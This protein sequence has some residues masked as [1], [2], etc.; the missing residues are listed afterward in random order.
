[1][2]RIAERGCG[3]ER[4]REGERQEERERKRVDLLNLEYLQRKLETYK[5]SACKTNKNNNK[6]QRHQAGKGERNAKKSRLSQRRETFANHSRRQETKKS[7]KSRKKERKKKEEN[8]KQKGCG[9]KKSHKEES[10]RKKKGL[11][12][13]GVWVSQNVDRHGED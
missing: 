10:K 12:Y 4:E 11:T 5:L 7:S 1:V 13:H 3:S 8:W 9:K 2:L 6:R